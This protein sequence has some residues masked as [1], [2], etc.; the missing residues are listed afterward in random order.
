MTRRA[1]VR[2][3]ALVVGKLVAHMQ[4]NPTSVHDA[5]EI[6]GLGL[7]AARGFL[8]RLHAEKA[9]RVVAWE[10]DSLNRYTTKVYLLERGPDAK[11]PKPIT[12]H[13]AR[14]RARTA[15]Q[16]LAPMHFMEAPC[17]A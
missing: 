14:R 7:K 10:L 3:N 17:N 13:R 1:P 2:I 5:M 16:R 9:A 15:A 11:K 6:T 8:L 4:Q 12:D